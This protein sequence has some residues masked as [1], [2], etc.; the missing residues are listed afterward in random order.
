VRQVRLPRSVDNDLI[1]FAQKNH[2]NLSEV[3]REAIV[4][5]LTAQRKA[6]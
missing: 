5:Y 6:S 2:R 4:E 3:M 1:E